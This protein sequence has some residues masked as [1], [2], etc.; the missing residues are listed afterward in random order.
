M[1]VSMA[2]FTLLIG[3][4]LA[5]VP[6]VAQAAE[7]SVTNLSVTFDIQPD[8]SVS[9]R[10][11]IHWRF[12][13][14]GRHGI[15]FGIATRERWDADPSKDVVYDVT[16]VTVSSP[17]GAPDTFTQTVN[18]EGSVG[19]LDLRIGSPEETVDGRDATY[20]I[21]YDVRGALRTF[22]DLPELYWDVTSNDYPHIEK[23]SVSVTAP[24]GV[25]RSRCLV[26]D[27]ECESEITTDGSA[28]LAGTDVPSGAVVTAV[29]G[30]VPGAVTIAEPTL[31]KRR[32]EYSVMT[33]ITSAVEVN[34]DGTTHVEQEMTYLLRD[35]AAE[36]SETLHWSLPL[37]RPYSRSEDQIFRITNLSVQ[38][39]TDVEERPLTDRDKSEAHQDMK[40]LIRPEVS[41]PSS[42]LTLSY[43]VE[44][45][46]ATESDTA[47]TQWILAPDTLKNAEAGDFTWELPDD[48]QRADCLT[49]WRLDD[50]PG[51]CRPALDLATSGATVSW[52]HSGGNLRGLDDAWIVADV[53][54]ASVGHAAPILEPGIEA[55]RRQDKVIGIGGGIAAL[56]GTVG[57]FLM[58]AR[59]KVGRDRRWADVAPGLTAPTGSPVR[60]ARRGDIVPVRFD[61]PDGSL[62]LAGMVLDGRPSSRHLAAQLVHMAVV[63]AV[64][65]Q[66]K[67]LKV[68]KIS[69]KPLTEKW[70]KQLYAGA[71]LKDEALDTAGMEQMGTAAD[72]HQ[73]GLLEDPLMFS[74][75]G[76][77]TAVPLHRNPVVGGV[78][79]VALLVF[80]VWVFGTGWFGSY[81]FLILAGMVVGS[82]AGL[83]LSAGTKPRRALEPNGT[84]LRD[85]V[86]GFRTYIATAEVNQLN[87]E[88]D[89]DI[90]RRY[91]PWAV[92]FGLTKRWTKVCQELADAGRIPSLD[93]S[94][95]IGATSADSIVA[96][97]ASFRRPLRSAAVTPS[98]GSSSS[99]S[100]GFFSGGG[101]GG[102]SGFSGGSSG[103]GGGGGTSAGSW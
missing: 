10:N 20:V 75:V 19:S 59:V 74:A 18:E 23:F 22:D 37:R 28:L 32:I 64:E 93:T 50:E 101:S 62:S 35:D 67:P 58:L 31:E 92:L 7:D 83:L 29:A 13:S 73:K 25:Q 27:A 86:E 84:A 17:S 21:S 15:D 89:Q 3:L 68:I 4:G 66:S 55:A 82:I 71:T 102:S 80:V 43:D 42:T 100:S 94:F 77:G 87:V 51:E 48:V 76:Q 24:E 63:G 98:S 72:A 30:L 90:Y 8:G 6:T 54:A 57:L 52:H 46:V 99:G 45:A 47:H 40:L 41:G 14:E 91:L 70:E 95:W 61:E 44:G 79:V 53:P 56:G 38:G 12:G 78:A 88:A 34:A 11:E 97:M 36:G 9:V 2:I 85:Q 96:G 49:M 1:G 33:N 60:F 39:A 103:G 16:D 65:V 69:P 5:L 26:G 81:G